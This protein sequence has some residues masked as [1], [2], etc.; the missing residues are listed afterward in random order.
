MTGFSRT[1]A[2]LPSSLLVFNLFFVDIVAS[3]DQLQYRI[4]SLASN[5]LVLH[6]RSTT[7]TYSAKGMSVQ[8]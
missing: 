1:N 4:A 3:I 5:L 8:V 2:V 6:W 7:H